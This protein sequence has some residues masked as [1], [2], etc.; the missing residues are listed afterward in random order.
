[1]LASFPFLDWT[2]YPGPPPSPRFQVDD[3]LEHPAAKFM[4]HPLRS[5]LQYYYRLEDTS[6]REKS[7]VYTRHKPWNTNREM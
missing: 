5:L 1:M 7:Q 3:R 2:V 6:D 4:G